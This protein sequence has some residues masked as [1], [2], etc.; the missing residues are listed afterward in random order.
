[1]DTRLKINLQRFN[2]NLLT[3][4]YWFDTLNTLLLLKPDTLHS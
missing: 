4:V 2:Q 1:M 3:G